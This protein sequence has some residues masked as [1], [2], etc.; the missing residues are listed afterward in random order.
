[1]ATAAAGIQEEQHPFQIIDPQDVE[2]TQ[3]RKFKLG[4]GTFADVFRGKYKRLGVD[5]AFK[6][7]KGVGKGGMD[8]E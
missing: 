5:A 2:L 8:L 3:D 1:M 6:V 7:L 4:S